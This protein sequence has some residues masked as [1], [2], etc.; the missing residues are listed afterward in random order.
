MAAL[1]EGIRFDRVIPLLAMSLGSQGHVEDSVLADFSVELYDTP[2]WRLV[3]EAVESGHLLPEEIRAEFGAFFREE[4]SK[5]SWSELRA[6]D[7]AFLQAAALGNASSLWVLGLRLVRAAIAAVDADE[8]EDL[9]Q[10]G[11]FLLVEAAEAGYARAQWMLGERFS[12]MQ[13][14]LDEGVRLLG[15]AASQGFEPAVTRL[16]ALFEGRYTF[17]HAASERKWLRR[18]ARAGVVAAQFDL[19]NE[20]YLQGDL[21]AAF[22]W[23]LQAAKAEH[24]PAQQRLAFYY[25]VGEGCSRDPQ[26]ADYWRNFVTGRVESEVSSSAEIEQ[27]EEP[28]EAPTEPSEN[29]QTEI[30]VNADKEQDPAVKKMPVGEVEDL[31]GVEVDTEVTAEGDEELDAESGDAEPDRG[32]EVPILT[33]EEALLEAEVIVGREN[34]ESFDEPHLSGAESEQE[35]I[36]QAETFY[37]PPA[38]VAS[39]KGLASRF[40]S[41]LAGVLR[42]LADKVS[43]SPVPDDRD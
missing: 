17:V 39:T 27:S 28:S 43:G 10:D 5:A 38:P 25:D 33:L 31:A 1:P 22:G 20:L 15:M 41:G 11:L 3:E 8:Q 14:G 2:L 34:V 6:V 9:N 4:L 23:M 36:N 40:R 35:S 21:K 29:F 30:K 12:R 19:A 37:R 13:D 26:R 16:D 18:F 32:L 42:R 24:L 7:R